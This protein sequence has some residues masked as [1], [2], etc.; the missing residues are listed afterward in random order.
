MK[1]V[2]K[3]CVTCW[4]LFWA[5]L[6][7]M[8]QQQSRLIS[9]IVTD[10]SG[11]PLIGANILDLTSKS[12]AVADLEGKFSLEVTPSSKLKISFVGFN[13][14][15]LSGKELKSNMVIVLSSDS[16]MLDELVVVGYGTQKKVNL[17][18][19]VAAVSSAD[20]EGKPVT[21]VVEALQGT[22]SGLV[23]QQSNSAPGARPSINIRGLNT[24]NDTSPL[25]LI[26]GIIGDIQNVNPSDIESISVLKDASSTAI[27]GSRASNGVI[28]ITTKKGSTEKNEITYEMQLGWQ[29]PTFLPKIVDS[30]VYAEMRNEA[31]LN[32]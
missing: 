3:W 11:E 12:G 9:G 4:L 28:L 26:D 24:M 22:T 29:T 17:T 18:G 19:A 7:I 21:N 6:P 1:H 15:I 23:I 13:D 30:W 10:D 14:R 8:A 5:C 16:K 2:M 20:L 25:V 32:S 31:L 27:Y